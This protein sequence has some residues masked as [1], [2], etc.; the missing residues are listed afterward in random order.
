MKKLTNSMLRGLAAL[1][2]AGLAL[3]PTPAQAA[4]IDF[5]VDESAVP[6]SNNGTF[7]ADVINGLYEEQ[8]TLT[9]TDAT[10]GSFTAVAFATFGQYG[11]DNN[12]VLTS[13][14]GGNQANPDTYRIYAIFTASGDYTQSVDGTEFDFVGTSGNATLWLDP[15]NNTTGTY[16]L[17]GGSGDDSL[18]VTSSNLLPGSG[19]DFNTNTNPITGNFNLVFGD[20]VLTALAKQLYPSLAN[21]VLVATVNGDFNEVGLGNPQNIGGDV[22]V[23]FEGTAVPEPA[24]LSLLG[25]GLLGAGAAARRRRKA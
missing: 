1:T 17:T 22:S 21:L 8:L 7:T 24:T 20:N 2:V 11:L 6:L 19:G 9:P 10:S 12:A 13:D 3:A 15:D 14:I 5:T 25:M 4:F 23:Q 16:V 18:L